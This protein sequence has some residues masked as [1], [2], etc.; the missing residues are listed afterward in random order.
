METLVAFDEHELSVEVEVVD[1]EIILLITQNTQPYLFSVKEDVVTNI[2]LDTTEII[3]KP[4]ADATMIGDAVQ[5]SSEYEWLGKSSD[6]YILGFEGTIYVFDK[7]GALAGRYTP[8]GPIPMYLFTTTDKL[9]FPSSEVLEVYSLPHIEKE[10]ELTITPKGI[11][12]FDGVGSIYELEDTSYFDGETMVSGET[13]INKHIMGGSTKE[14]LVKGTGYQFGVN[15][16]VYDLGVDDK[17]NIYLLIQDDTG[18]TSVYRYYFDPTISTMTTEVLD[19]FTMNPSKPLNQAMV[20]FG[21]KYPHVKVNITIGT[22]KMGEQ[23]EDDIIKKLNSE[24]LAGKGPDLLLLDGLSLDSMAEKGFLQDL[25]GKVDVSDLFANMVDTYKKDS[26]IYALPTAVKIPLIGGRSEHLTQ[27]MTMEQLLSNMENSVGG[28]PKIQRFLSKE[29][30]V[31]GAS[32]PVGIVYLEGGGPSPLKADACYLTFYSQEA[33]FEQFYPAYAQEIWKDNKLR[34]T[35]LKDFIT[36]TDRVVKHN[37]IKPFTYPTE[38]SEVMAMYTSSGME[39]NF[40]TNW[41]CLGDSTL[42]IDD[43]PRIQELYTMFYDGADTK[44]TG[45]VTPVPSDNGTGV[46]IPQQAVGVLADANQVAIDFVQV[47]LSTQVQDTVPFPVNKVSFLKALDDG[48]SRGLGKMEKGIENVTITTD[49]MAMIE[50]LLPS[51]QDNYLE[52]IV[53]GETMNYYNG[54]HS[55][56]TAVTAIEESAKRYLSEK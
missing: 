50:S 18:R 5:K 13:Q 20:A 31:Y 21:Q 1:D 27:D 45:V 40:S 36:Q 46:F 47:M 41:F 14:T 52:S 48:Q 56:E 35:A 28:V 11:M 29:K 32:T 53:R 54:E 38:P 3:P 44:V 17:D 7:S 25:S 12:F 55:I 19:I 16:F 2:P 8:Q 34:Q 6:Y 22:D 10:K 24:I 30:I 23:T 43:L 26:G 15:N 49:I 4:L 42:Y 39:M 51:P 37:Q 33:L 9:V